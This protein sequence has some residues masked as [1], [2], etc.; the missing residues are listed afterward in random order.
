[1]LTTRAIQ[2]L[3]EENKENNPVS[4]Q[5][6]STTKTFL[7]FHEKIVFCVVYFSYLAILLK[8]NKTC[9]LNKNRLYLYIFI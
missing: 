4:I 9:Q 5:N 3:E 8:R 1:V 7:L 6:N 2:T